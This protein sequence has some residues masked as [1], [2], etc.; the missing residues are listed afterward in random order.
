MIPTNEQIKA[1]FARGG[2]W[3]V[4][5]PLRRPFFVTLAIVQGRV[6]EFATYDS[7]DLA[8]TVE[9]SPWL[10]KAEWLAVNLR[11]DCL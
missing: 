3:R 5:A 1:H 8:A 4:V 10:R 11:G 6:G 7:G 2:L 9:D